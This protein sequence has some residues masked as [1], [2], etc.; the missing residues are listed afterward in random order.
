M[1]LLTQNVPQHSCNI[2]Q[3][4][5]NNFWSCNSSTMFLQHH[6]TVAASQVII[7]GCV[8]KHNSVLQKS[9]LKHC[10]CCAR[11]PC[12]VQQMHPCMLEGFVVYVMCV[13]VC[14][15]SACTKT[16]THNSH[17]HTHKLHTFNH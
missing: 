11:V 17:T 5:H 14:V 16:D 2:L 10:K 9:T 4:S 8:T 15:V 6:R 1:F 7:A 3:H 12:S 13:S